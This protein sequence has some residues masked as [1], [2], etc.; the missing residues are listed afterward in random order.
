MAINEV[1]KNNCNN[2]E[3]V[4]EQ[5]SR[6]VITPSMVAIST[7]HFYV[8]EQY[9]QRDLSWERVIVPKRQG[10]VQWKE[11]SLDTGKQ[12]EYGQNSV[13]WVD[14]WKLMVYYC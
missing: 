12:K 9:E 6:L 14:A 2:P 10:T 3:Q 5:W 13:S 4:R 7:E 8:V 1:G 11:V